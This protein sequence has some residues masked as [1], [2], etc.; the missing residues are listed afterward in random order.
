MPFEIVKPNKIR[1]KEVSMSKFHGST[2]G[3]IAVSVNLTN[4][5][6]AKLG[7]DVKAEAFEFLWGNGDDFGLLKVVKHARGMGF[8]RKPSQVINRITTGRCP[9]RMVQEKMPLIDVEYEVKG[10]ALLIILPEYFYKKQPRL[11]E[12]Q[13]TDA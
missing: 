1:T 13:A 4:E 2:G 7:W 8:E 5:I 6:I 9:S 3:R 11:D 10:P 12:E